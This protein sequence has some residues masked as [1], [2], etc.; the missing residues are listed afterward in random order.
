MSEGVVGSKYT[1]MRIMIIS[2][3]YLT[4]YFLEPLKFC[5]TSVQQIASYV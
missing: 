1:K 5:R 3:W 2:E 4:L